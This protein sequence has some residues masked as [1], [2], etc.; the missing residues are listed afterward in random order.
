MVGDL[1]TGFSFRPILV[2]SDFDRASG[3]SPVLL[4]SARICL[5]LTIL[6]SALYLLQ[7]YV[8]FP[9]SAGGRF[10]LIAV[11]LGLAVFAQWRGL[12]LL[13]TSLLLL[14]LSVGWTG[15]HTYLDYG[16]HLAV[17]A[18][19]RFTNVMVIAPLA[20]LLFVSHKS[21][22]VVFLIYLFVFLA[23]HASMLYQYYG[24]SMATLVQDYLAIRADLI[25]HMT[26]VGEPNVGGKLAVLAYI[27]GLTIPRRLPAS[28]ALAGL[29]VAFVVMTLSKAAVLGVCVASL[30]LFLVSPAERRADLAFRGLLGGLF[31]VVFILLIGADAYLIAAVKSVLGQVRGEPSAMTDLAYRQS[32]LLL[33]LDFRIESLAG[34]L[35]LL[36]GSSFGVA[37][38]AAYEH[39]GDKSYVVLPHNS[40]LEMM[41][42]GG[43]VMLG[44]MIYL[45]VSAIRR[46]LSEAR[47]DGSPEARCA[48]VC[49]IMLAFWMLVYPVIYEPV[50]GALLWSLI[51]YG[52]RITSP[53]LGLPERNVV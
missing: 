38:S 28:V 24:G 29:A 6:V 22:K 36:F 7:R 49:L 15:I 12:I 53:S 27:I 2:A 35:T 1:R 21:L 45:L 50:T 17:V 26:I 33:D 41:L 47:S 19:I 32:G 18:T 46:F 4:A 34:L 51:G 16:P 5:C 42:T 20:V 10:V 39:L 40:Y 9:F 52:H 11:T 8:A 23:A 25:R 3:G 30:A 13:P 14:G 31:G 43:I 48:L 44:S 37:G